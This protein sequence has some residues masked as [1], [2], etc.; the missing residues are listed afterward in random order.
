MGGERATHDALVITVPR[1]QHL[2][3]GEGGEVCFDVHNVH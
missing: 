1:H 3:D 2:S